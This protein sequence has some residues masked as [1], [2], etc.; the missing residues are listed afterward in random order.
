MCI[1][2]RMALSHA[3]RPPAL[4][5]DPFNVAPAMTEVMTRLASHPDRLFRAQADLFSRYMDG[6]RAGLHPRQGRQALQPSGMDRES[7]LRRGQAVLPAHLGL[8]EQPRLQ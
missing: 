7:G 6:D 8:A 4:T 5:P 3:E 2:D 1:R